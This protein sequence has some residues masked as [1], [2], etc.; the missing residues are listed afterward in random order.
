MSGSNA[1]EIHPTG[2]DQL[3]LGHNRRDHGDLHGLLQGLNMSAT[4]AI[5]LQLDGYRVVARLDILRDIHFHPESEGNLVKIQLVPHFF[6]GD[7]HIG[8]H[9]RCLGQI[10]LLG[11]GN[12]HRS[13]HHNITD[14]VKAHILCQFRFHLHLSKHLIIRM[15]IQL[16]AN[17]L[18]CQGLTAMARGIRLRHTYSHFFQRGYLL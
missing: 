2:I 17:A 18:T 6:H 15:D 7:Q 16:I 3:L 5:T 4:G 13:I 12:N 8:H 1:I 14:T 11:G 10:I 9:A